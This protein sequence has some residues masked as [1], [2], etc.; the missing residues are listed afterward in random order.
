MSV[1][2]QIHISIEGFDL[3]LGTGRNSCDFAIL[4]DGT[5]ILINYIP[6]TVVFVC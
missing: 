3:N 1:N 2:N 4:Q 5:L 6:T